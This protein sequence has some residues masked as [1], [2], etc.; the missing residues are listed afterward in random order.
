M[1]VLVMALL[2][3]GLPAQAAPML[4]DR[5]VAVVG[6]EIILESELDQMALPT[7]REG[8]PDT[9]EGKRK[10][11]AHRRKVLDSLI[12]KQLIAQQAK[13]M[14]IHAT[15][16]EVRKAI[17][18]VKK[19]NG[20]DDAQF[21]EALRSQGFTLESYKKQLRQQLVEL[22]VIN[23]AV[24]ARVSVSDDEVRA[25]YAQNVRQLSG[26][27]QQVHL[28]Q[29]L[30]PVARDAPASEVEARR[31]A[32]AAVIDMLRAGEEFDAVA[33]ARGGGDLGWLARGDLPEELREVVA[34]MD[35]GDIRGPVRSDWGFHILLLVEKKDSDVRPLEEVKEELRRQLYEQQVDK[36]LQSWLKE[37]RRKS[38]I[39]VRL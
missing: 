14:K 21:L 7:F 19:N 16:E 20:L 25:Y 3:I 13:E 1:R 31:K 36:A 39:D 9:P 6:E 8:D 30:F 33:R 34:A 38:H 15:E 29:I 2:C 26:D 37:L 28:K 12:E 18:E 5:V 10:L 4:L 27:S 32:A 17:E 23:Q 22:K 24:R 11:E 35:V